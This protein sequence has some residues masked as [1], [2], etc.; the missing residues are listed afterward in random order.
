M[1][2]LDILSILGIAI[3]TW[4]G[5]Y[6]IA[7]EFK[8]NAIFL[9]VSVSVVEYIIY[10]LLIKQYKKINDRLYYF[11]AW[12]MGSYP[13]FFAQSEGNRWTSSAVVKRSL[14]KGD[15]YI[16]NFK[17]SKD[18]KRFF[19][20]FSLKKYY[21][22]FNC[23]VNSKEL[24]KSGI[25]FGSMGAGKTEFYNSLIE[26]DMFNRYVINDVKGDFTQK[27]YNKRK[28][29]ILNPYDERGSFWNPFEEAKES[30][31]VIEIFMTNLFNALAGN[32]K[33]F[34][35]ASAK[36]R[37][38]RLFNEINYKKASLS[39]KEKL[40]LYIEELRKYFDSA[41]K[42]GRNSEADVASTMKI[43]FEF[44][45]Y[46][47]FCIQNGEKTFTIKEFLE[48][49]NRKLFLLSRDDQ[50]S[51]LTPFYTGFL[52]AFIAVMLSQKD[53]KEDLTLFVLDEYLSFAKNMDD[54]T[55]EGLHTRIRSKG[56]CLLPGVQFFPSGDNEQL[57]QKILNSAN[58]W[59]LFEGIDQ[60]TLDKLNKIIGQV[61][62]KKA[63]ID[64]SKN[65]NS[66]E[67]YTSEKVDLI[68]TTI[69]Q[70]LNFE[71]ITFIPSK[72][73]LYRGYTP[74]I[75]DIFNKNKQYI[76][77][78]NITLFYRGRL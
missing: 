32:K 52:A 2:K 70:N 17:F 5:V 45:D 59:F 24:T 14:K 69:L 40:N 6:N 8:L 42:S 29:I 54:E 13:N 41:A 36:E 46:I 78:K 61:R 65:I 18:V 25:V 3:F 56:G 34:F 68:N 44:F 38:M 31:F 21:E 55:L 43:T 39:S 48:S 1:V 49:K 9:F 57:T 53:N 20:F 15:L 75:D 76:K 74:L 28:D 4:I 73:M 63:T 67:T 30:P 77:N 23:F 58:F 33:D 47:N 11:G 10:M 64:I 19:K 12:A 60:F 26:Q 71:H 27:F 66:N 62:Y 72:G 7:E 35:S 37:Y 50:K 16:D 51:K 22:N